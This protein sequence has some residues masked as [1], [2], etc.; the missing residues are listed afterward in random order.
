MSKIENKIKEL[1][2]NYWDALKN[3]T[4]VNNPKI[5]DGAWSEYGKYP[6]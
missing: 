5:Y 3:G 1:N 4:M 6:A 2:I